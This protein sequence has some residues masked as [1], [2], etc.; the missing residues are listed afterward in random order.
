[1]DFHISDA[2]VIREAFSGKSLLIEA[3]IFDERVW[4]PKKMI[5]DDSEIWKGGDSPGTLV[6]KEWFAE[7]KGW[8]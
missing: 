1:M 4:V 2:K 5:T 3:P 8:I 6:V 7:K